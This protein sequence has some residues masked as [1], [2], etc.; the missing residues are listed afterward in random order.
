[1]TR[2]WQTWQ[3]ES[4]R[5]THGPALGGSKLSAI[6]NRL[7]AEWICSCLQKNAPAASGTT[8][9]GAPVMMTEESGCTGSARSSTSAGT[10]VWTGSRPPTIAH[11]VLLPEGGMTSHRC[12]SACTA[13]VH[14]LASKHLHH[15]VNVLLPR[16]ID[17]LCFARISG[18][19]RHHRSGCHH[20]SVIGNRRMINMPMTASAV[21]NATCQGGAQ[22][23]CRGRRSEGSNA[24]A[25][26]NKLKRTTFGCWKGSTRSQKYQAYGQGAVWSG[27][28]SRGLIQLQE[29]KTWHDMMSR[30]L[31][32]F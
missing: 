2:S 25:V 20:Q 10:K 15:N 19:R 28:A 11:S 32:E 6:L 30:R 14:H 3:S 21:M 29:L 22:E 9:R 1:M 13:P 26:S 12:S 27:S 18:R 4:S 16:H 17:A 5:T 24:C 23:D 31:H 7:F 8:M